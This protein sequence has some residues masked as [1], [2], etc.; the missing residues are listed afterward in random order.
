MNYS[1]GTVTWELDADD[2][3]FDSTLDRS[4]TKARQFGNE[5]DSVGKKA[6]SNFAADMSSSFGI[7]ADG[8]GSLLKG[9]TVFAL[10]SAVGFGAATKAAFDQVRQVENATFALKAYETNAD[11]VNTVLSQLV[12]YARS[13]LGVLFQR[14]DLFDA[15]STLKIYG[16]QTDKLVGH[17]KILSKGVAIGKTN[18]QEL[19]EILG[20]VIATGEITSDTFEVLA[21]RGIKLPDSLRGAKVSA[22]QLFEALDKAL[23]DSILEGRANTIDGAMIRLQSAFRDLGGAILGVDTDT[24]KLIK[25]GFGDILVSSIDKLRLTL[26]DPEFVKAMRNIGTSLAEFA[27]T[28]IPLLLKGIKLLGQNMKTVIAVLS[29][30]VVAFVAAK[31][32]SVAFAIA[33]AGSLGIWAAAITAVIAGLTFLEVRFGFVTKAMKELSPVI[34]PIV[35]AVKDLGDAITKDLVP[36]FKKLGEELGP[37]MPMLKEV[38]GV[39]FKLS[40]LTF[41]PLVTG[42]KNA[43]TGLTLLAKGLAF[44]ARAISWTIELWK[45][46]KRQV[47]SFVDTLGRI[48][49]GFQNALGTADSFVNDKMNAIQNRISGALNAIIG[50]FAPFKDNFKKAFSD[51]LNGALGAIIDYDK[52]TLERWK[53]NFEN[54]KKSVMEFGPNLYNSLKESL[55]NGVRA[56]SEWATDVYNSAKNAV[57]SFGKAITD[58]GYNLYTDTKNTLENFVKAV[59]D[60]FSGIPDRIDGLLRNT[61]GSMGDKTQQGVKESFSNEDK[62]K[63]IG[64][65][66]LGGFAL[67]FVSIAIALVDIGSKIMGKIIEG[68]VGRL[69]D[70]VNNG[71]NIVLFMVQGIE[72]LG[73][74]L[75]DRARNQAN[76]VVGAFKAVGGALYDAGRN[77][78]QS[79]LNGMGSL[80]S[81]VAQFMVNKLPKAI[82][83]P[84]KKAMGIAS[85]S[86][87]FKEYGVNT[88]EGYVGGVTSSL[89]MVQ[90][91][92]GSF[93]DVVTAPSISNEF[94][95]MNSGYGGGTP[96]PIEVNQNIYNDVDMEQ[97]LR[98]LAWRLSN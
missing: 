59:T 63:Q 21:R 27:V 96:A 70:M 61:G 89:K 43:I 6:S 75:V 53:Q 18:F 60:F 20:Q 65:T 97:G 83:G 91:A 5:L 88:V 76:A 14:Q 40:L 86:K 74:Y 92:M 44:G 34:T 48:K 26:R 47:D 28:V 3:K 79:L 11:K 23:P 2:K 8:L 35:N 7:V 57:M 71:K 37:A 1:G 49:T 55:S 94:D 78:I 19:S 13:D 52:R 95:G 93:S 77:M 15:A 84:F 69:Q 41:L 45:D 22:D 17:V 4:S 62:M 54:L 46:A 80:L 30:L 32:A 9:V 67:V 73:G 24:S 31:I 16:D 12:A 64:M 58:W 87:V 81:T 90:N 56:I 33:A 66:I 85:P 50:F 39:L 72:S 25:G 82:Q 38:G 68:I 98:D 42:I 29:G 10:G 51:A 36:S